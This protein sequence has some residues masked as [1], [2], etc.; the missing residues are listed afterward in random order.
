MINSPS[1]IYGNKKL[2]VTKDGSFSF[3]SIEYGESYKTKSI[4]AYSESRH[5]FAN[6]GGMRAKFSSGDVRVLDICFGIGMN[7][8]VTIEEYLRCGSSYR[9]HIV[10]VEKDPT[11]VNIVK[12]A[13]FL[14][15]YEGYRVLRELL[16][17]GRYGNITLELYICDALH[18]I[19]FL[20]GKFHAIYFDPFSEKHNPEMWGRQVF[21]KMGE[22]LADGGGLM[23]YASNAALRSML[24]E[25][26][27]M[28]T[29]IPSVGGRNHPSIMCEIS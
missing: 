28:V 20:S 22:L 3:Y 7:L 1:T 25:L 23:T 6:A 8:A 4:G 15:P 29:K 12:N 24:A 27:F 18:F 5:K 2:I 19:N 14:F 11:L 16:R 26:G 13:S 9:L 10:S 17:C 21:I